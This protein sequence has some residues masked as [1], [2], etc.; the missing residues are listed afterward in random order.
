MLFL[1]SLRRVVFGGIIGK[2]FEEWACV[3]AARPPAMGLEQFAKN[4][5]E[6][7]EGEAQPR[8]IDCSFRCDLSV[9]VN[10]ERLRVTP[11]SAAFFV[12]HVADFTQPDLTESRIIG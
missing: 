6:M 3:E 8:R 9:R 12:T 1:K 7:A 10:S 4:V 11:G 2:K 5:R